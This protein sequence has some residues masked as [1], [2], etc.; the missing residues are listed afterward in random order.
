MRHEE[1]IY[2]YEFL[3]KKSL[4]LKIVLSTL[5]V[6]ACALLLSTISQPCKTAF[7]A[8][9]STPVYRLYNYLSSEHLYTTD[10]SEYQRLVDITNQGKS[11]WIKEGVAWNAPTK[12]A[13]T[14]ETQT[15]NVKPVYRLYNA[16]LGRL[17]RS[18]HYYTADTDEIK[19]LTTK[20]YGWKNEGVI[21]YSGGSVSIYT[22]YS[23]KLGSAHLYTATKKEYE[24][25]DKGWNKEPSKNSKN[26][27]PGVFQA[28][29]AGKYEVNWSV[30]NNRYGNGT[31]KI[32]AKCAKNTYID[33]TNNAWKRGTNIETWVSNSTNAQKWWINKVT[34]SGSVVQ[35]TNAWNDLRLDVN[36]GSSSNG[37]NVQAWTPNDSN[38]QK[39]QVEISNE[40][41]IRF[42]NLASQKFLD[43]KGGGGSGT[44]V[45]SYQ[46]NGGLSQS[47]RLH[48]IG[49]VSISGNA[50]LDGRLRSIINNNFGATG[51]LLKKS[52]NYVKGF[53]YRSGSIYPGGNWSPGFAL[54]MLRRGSG[55]C[56]RFAALFAHL[57][58]ALNYN[59]NA[60]SGEI[61]MSG[62]WGAHGWV[63]VYMNGKTYLCDPEICKYVSGNFYMTTYAA[64]PCYYR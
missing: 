54:E 22:A 31:Y 64:A 60:I 24:G 4:L 18:S 20:K 51:D 49:N 17:G 1:Y 35:I 32:E 2:I 39:W 42:K 5:L 40:G 46:G 61:L 53:A 36:N 45:Q 52:Y 62:G 55:N 59:A 41:N 33:L 44:N 16:G 27:V 15:S 21:F 3:N 10:K 37:A 57:A 8:E 13:E 29:S 38:A 58:R 28:V 14:Q 63:E 43:V 9:S 25:L 34:N 48:Q 6:F 23:E 50:E 11:N 56:Y 7:A 26:E 30:C 47:F 12:P 19:T